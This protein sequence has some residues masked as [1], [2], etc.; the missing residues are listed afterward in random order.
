[1]L[2]EQIINGLTIGSMYALIAIGYTMV[3]GVLEL[4][5]FAHGSV[6]MFSS[7]IT[8]VLYPLVLPHF[9]QA[10]L[11]SILVT[12]LV[13][14]LIDVIG[15]RRLR[16]KKAPKIAALIS[17]LGMSTILEQIVQIVWGT[18][19]KP[20]PMVLNFGSVRLLGCTVKVSQLVILFTAIGLMAVLSLFIYRT[21]L[22]KAMQAVAQDAEAARIM[23]VPVE[24]IITLTFMLGSALAA[25]AGTLV[26]TYYQS[27]DTGMGFTVGMKALSSAVLGGVGNL[28]GAMVGGLLVG[29]IETLGAV[30]VSSGY[31]NAIAFV[32]LIAIILVKPNGLFGK[33]QIT[34]V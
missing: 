16:Q 25:V 1:M 5:N 11:A 33:A 13:G 12:G 23:G 19:A 3:F 15:L 18:D 20:F 8:W 21:S 28:P 4:V 2:T 6:Y 26:A 34:K 29:L 30:Y 9:W 10:F 24:R 14:C 32:I 27:I 7:Y 17:T 22:G 31:R